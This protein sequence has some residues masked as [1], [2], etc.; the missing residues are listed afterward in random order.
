MFLFEACYDL[1]ELAR[2]NM[3]IHTSFSRCAKPEMT[4]ENI[5]REAERAGLRAIAL[6]DHSPAEGSYALQVQALR[7]QVAQA[8]SPVKVYVGAELSAYGVGKYSET[9]ETE[10]LLDYRLFSHNH[11]HQD[12]WEH[13]EERTPEGYKQHAL[14][15]L[16]ALF[17][18]GRADCIAHPLFGRFLD[19]CEDRTEIPRAISDT[20]LGELMQEGT[21]AQV[22]WEINSGAV[23]GD[24]IFYRRY[25]QIGREAGAVFLFGTDTHRLAGIDPYK[26]LPVLKQIL[27]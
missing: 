1:D 13:P 12:F 24:P 15:V 23:M 27:Y 2:N 9:P 11:Y 16:R 6:T 25:F 22:A 18:S 21:R 5:L 19:I 3:H 14:A 4:V 8:Q 26:Q 17:A 10:A 20:E 7:R